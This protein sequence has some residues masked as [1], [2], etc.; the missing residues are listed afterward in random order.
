MSNIVNINIKI[1]KGLTGDGVARGIYCLV[2]H[3]NENKNMVIDRKNI[4]LPEGFYCYVDSHHDLN[5]RIKEHVT[6][7]SRKNVQK[8]NMKIDHVIKHANQ[9]LYH[10][11]LET[12]KYSA[13]KI[14]REL[15]ALSEYSIKGFGLSCNCKSHLHYFKENP[16]F[17]KE[18]H[19]VFEGRKSS[20]TD[21]L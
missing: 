10:N 13:C 1:L 15:K 7:F 14:N 4:K 6:V 12:E 8:K 19:H 9:I 17:L 20:Q 11:T 3:L 21:K 16:L 18:F 2:L 5:N